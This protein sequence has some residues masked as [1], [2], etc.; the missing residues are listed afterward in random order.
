MHAK[1]QN[2]KVDRRAAWV[3]NV[4]PEEFTTLLSGVLPSW[5]RSRCGEWAVTHRRCAGERNGG[6]H[7]KSLFDLDGLRMSIT[8]LRWATRY[9]DVGSGNRVLRS[10]S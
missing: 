2:Y 3:Y 1:R 10:E 4:S 7:I 8:F 9:V 5:R 6:S